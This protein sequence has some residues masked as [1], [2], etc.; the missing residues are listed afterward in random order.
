MKEEEE[1]AGIELVIAAFLTVVF[2]AALISLRLK[3]PSTL[4]LVLS[5]FLIVI[6]ATLLS[7][8]GS[9]LQDPMQSLIS[10]IRSIYSTLVQGGGGGGLFV[11]LVVPP[12]IFEAMIH[13]RGSDL[14]NVI[15]PSLALGNNR[16]SHCNLRWRLNIMETCRSFFLRFLPIC[17]FNR[18]N[19]CGHCF[20]SFSTRKSSLTIG[21]ALRYRSRV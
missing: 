19:R 3:V 6:V 16:C 20:G 10:Q 17:C 9:P 2:I 15:K 18:S 13:I 1:T 11:G 5:G 14:K 8:Q 21:N 4:I 7:L 12:L